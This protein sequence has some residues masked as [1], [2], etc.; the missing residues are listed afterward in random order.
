M[1]F[2]ADFHIHSH[3]SRAT[4]KDLD[5]PHLAIWGAY[6]GIQ[7]IGTGDF[8]HP[9]WYR[10]LRETLEPAE[11]GLFRLKPDVM[12]TVHANVPPA[13]RGPVRFLLTVEISSI[14]KRGERVRKI[15]NVVVVPDFESVE[16]IQ[17]R[18]EKIGNIRSDGRP[19]LGLD[20]RDLLEIV[21][22]TSPLAYLIPAHIWTP[23]FSLLGSKSGF[24]AVEACF[25]DL[26]SEIF[27]LETGLSSDPPMNWRLSS[28]DRYT[29]VSN[30]DAHSPGKLGRE[31]NL[32][33]TE[34][35]YGAILEALKTRRGFLGTIEF[36]PEEGKYHLDGHRKC[37]VRLSPEETQEQKGR[38]PA[39]GK[40]VTVGVM[41]RVATLA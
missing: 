26:S 14:Y 31:A 20:A 13:V 4:S 36:F 41:H 9:G 5:L 10:E 25:G 39:C 37:G 38:C 12:R 23:W 40:P 24:D 32:F 29:L 6:K 34:L 17:R 2:I 22:E 8:T 11:D 18:L 15:H 16:R 19:I 1:R 33:D 28:L 21:L 7:V 30:S 3:Y 27:A 35:S